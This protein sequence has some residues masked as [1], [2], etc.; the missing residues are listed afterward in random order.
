MIQA[1]Y[2]AIRG[3]VQIDRDTPEAMDAAVSRLFSALLE[4]N[5]LKSADFGIILF[6]LTPDIRAKNPAASL[7]ASHPEAAT[8]ALFCMQEAVV[9]GMMPRVIRIMAVT[10]IALERDVRNVY[11]DGAQALRPDYRYEA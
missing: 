5:D 7:R 2:S 9:E 8:A 6:T 10:K 11:L 4:A 1:G 3:A